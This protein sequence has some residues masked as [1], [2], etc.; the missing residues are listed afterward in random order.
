MFYFG[1][2]LLTSLLSEFLNLCLNMFQNI[3]T[4]FSS[5]YS[6]LLHKDMELKLRNGYTLPVEID[7]VNSQMRGVKCFFKHLE[8][9]GGELIL[10]EYFGRSKFNVYI[11]GSN[12]SE[13]PYPEIAGGLP[14]IGDYVLF[15]KI[16]TSSIKTYKLVI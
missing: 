6:N 16:W 12:G 7:L 4:K 3:P 14:A 1:C 11:I 8:L 5:K 13:I 10:F 9:R 15:L 2:R